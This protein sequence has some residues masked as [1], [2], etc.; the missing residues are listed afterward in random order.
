MLQN[1]LVYKTINFYR[2]KKLLK[3]KIDLTPE[4][5]SQ[6]EIFKICNLM[7]FLLLFKYFRFLG[8]A[9]ILNSITLSDKPSNSLELALGI[10]G[11]VVPVLIM[12][13]CFVCYRKRRRNSLHSSAHNPDFTAS[14]GIYT[15]THLPEPLRQLFQRLPSQGS[16]K[17]VILDFTSFFQ[18][19]CK[20]IKLAKALLQSNFSLSAITISLLVSQLSRSFVFSRL[21]VFCYKKLLVRNPTLRSP[22]N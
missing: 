21:L 2:F 22:K 7:E 8:L 20:H 3:T 19:K 6:K 14:T 10:T 11:A 13:I 16:G 9:F 4:T 15:E 12:A 18:R 5:K 17:F 1:Q